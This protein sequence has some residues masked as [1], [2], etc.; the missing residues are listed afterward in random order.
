MR[1]SNHLPLRIFVFSF[2]ACIS[3]G[4]AAE[5]FVSKKGNDGNDGKSVGT[6]FL[7]IQK[8]VDALKPGDVLTI[9]PG[10]YAEAVSRENLGGDEA[11]T[12]VRA[13]MPGTVLLRGNVPVSGFRKVEGTRFVSVCDY[14]GELYGVSEVDSLKNLTQSLYREELE[15]LPGAYFHDAK[16]GKLYVSSTDLQPAEKHHYRVNVLPAH[17]IY[18]KSPRRVVVEGLAVTGFNFNKAL[19]FKEGFSKWGILMEDPARCVVRQCTAFLNGSGICMLGNKGGGGN[20]VENCTAYGND[21]RFNTEGGNIAIFNGGPSDALR[22]NYVYRSGGYGQRF[23]ITDQGNSV[24]SDSLGWGNSSGDLWVKGVRPTA[25]PIRVERVVSMNGQPARDYRH[26]LVGQGERRMEK[27]D[28]P[29]DSI[30]LETAGLDPEAEF[31]DTAHFDFRLQGTSRFKAGAP[32]GLAFGPFPDKGDIYYVSG[33]GSDEA[34]GMSVAQAW[35]TISHALGKLKKGD[36]LFLEGGSYAENVTLSGEGISL[37]A[38]GKNPVVLTGDWALTG[39]KNLSLKR[40]VFL[41]GWKAA[42]GENLDV[43]NC[44][45]AAQGGVQAEG[46]RGLRMTHCVLA[47]TLQLPGCREAYL[48]GNL[49]AGSPALEVERMEDIRYSNYNGYPAEAGIWRVSSAALSLG[50]VQ[51]AQDQYSIVADAGVGISA[52]GVALKNRG[53]V[54]GLGPLATDIGLYF[55]ANFEPLRAVGPFV[56]SVGDTTA[57]LEWWTSRP[58]V[59]EF[60]W[61]ETPACENKKRLTHHCYSGYSLTGLTPGKKYYYQ[62][63]LIEPYRLLGVRQWITLQDEK[64]L[65]GEFTTEKEPRAAQTWYVAPDGDN[66][67]SG[68]SRKEA[69]KTLNHAAARVGAGDTVLVAGGDYHETVWLRATGDKGR[70]I[71]FRGM[72]NERVNFDGI[73][74]GLFAAFVGHGKHHQVFDSFYASNL[75]RIGSH[76]VFLGV[77]MGSMFVLTYSQNVEMRRSLMDGAGPGYSPGFVSATACDNLVMSNCVAIGG[78]GRPYFSECSGLRVEHSV[79]FRNLI[80][81]LQIFNCSDAKVTQNIFTDGSP[82]KF[83]AAIIETDSAVTEAGNCFFPRSPQEKKPLMRDINLTK[84]GSLIANPEFAVLASVPLKNEDGKEIYPPDRLPP[85]P[86]RL[87]DFLP[88]NPVVVKAGMGLQPEEVVPISPPASVRTAVSPPA[89]PEEKLPE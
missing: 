43:D 80:N 37:R 48:S 19:T 32:D 12:V 9:G 88:T 46:V 5:F 35:K 62:I 8:G 29:L 67:N 64:T 1:I 68:Q 61:G 40:L 7:S 69:W 77:E 55:E 22:G 85:G 36:T 54:A 86:F 75:G 24:M 83:N 79:L 52:A 2:L 70:P 72:P 89:V 47:G 21:S 11:D 71:T 53:T 34:D 51:A 6:A 56:H 41:G 74:R 38:R 50:E 27:S 60:S 28:T 81:Q 65:K 87:V 45:F 44:A 78:F 76:Q 63:K 66:K 17:G 23:Y 82:A 33:K 73:S 20:V 31:A 15:F 26:S 84:S 18:L 16:A 39:A 4:T 25:A 13:E 59:T 58:A 3:L 30:Y 10:E 14:A 42:G 49:Y 57:N